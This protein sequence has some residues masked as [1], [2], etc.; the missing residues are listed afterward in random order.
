MKSLSLS[1]WRDSIDPTILKRG[2]AYFRDWV[3]SDFEEYDEWMYQGFVDGSEAYTIR[4]HCDG[5]TISDTSCTCP[6][7]HG[8]IC[9]HIVAGICALE[10]FLSEWGYDASD[11]RSWTKKKKATGRKTITEKLLETYEG[12]PPEKLKAFIIETWEYDRVFRERFLRLVNLQ[13]QTWDFEKDKKKYTSTIRSSIRAVMTHGF[14]E[15]NDEATA[16]EWAY[17]ILAEAKNVFESGNI[18][19]TWARCAALMETIYPE[20]ENIDG[21]NGEFSTV[22]AET[23]ALFTELC[24]KC[25][26]AKSPERS[27]LFTYLLIQIKSPLYDGWSMWRFFSK[28][29]IICVKTESEETVLR[30]ALQDIPGDRYDAS[31]RVELEMALLEKVGKREEMEKLIDTHLDI[32]TFRHRRIHEAIERWEYQVA[33][34]LCEEKLQE[35]ANWNQKIWQAYLL[36]IAGLEKD[37]ETIQKYLELFF[38]EYSEWNCYDQLKW[39]YDSFSWKEKVKELID[40]IQKKSFSQRNTLLEIYKREEMWTDFRTYLQ[41]VCTS[42]KMGVENC[43]GIL[44]AWDAEIKMHCGDIYSHL[45]L[46]LIDTGLIGTTGRSTY[47]SYAQWLRRIIK[48]EGEG[49]ITPFIER[50][51]VVYKN[52][53]AMLE[54]FD[55][56]Q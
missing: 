39:M 31:T 14:V 51:R 10:I 16:A 22:L 11:M 24:E 30:K 50:W 13:W 21:S 19:D 56:F 9:K 41:E 25:V 28:I 44:E 36:N 34:N 45:I 3:V 37:T 33:K 18:A 4:I 38:I 54:E 55:E 8:G 17:A 5:S 15:W 46:T 12:I 43:L 23:E 52:R 42:Q 47:K 35:K 6:Y 7:D 1:H 40:A 29:A 27:D 26:L 32:D 49:K 20:L 53:K 48:K 2:Q